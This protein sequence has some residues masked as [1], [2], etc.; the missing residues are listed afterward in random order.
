MN[1]HE[2]GCSVPLS[3]FN[4]MSVELEISLNPDLP[5]KL[6]ETVG[7]MMKQMGMPAD[8]IFS[9]VKVF[10]SLDFKMEFNTTD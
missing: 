10:N 7:P 8:M 4:K 9:V 1:V 2:S 6:Q 5:G 3:I